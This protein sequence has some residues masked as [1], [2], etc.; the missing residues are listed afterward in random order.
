MNN[1]AISS[2]LTG[3]GSSYNYNGPG[4]LVPDTETG[5]TTK[6]GA[7]ATIDQIRQ[8][9][10][11]LAANGLSFNYSG[12]GLTGI[13]NVWDFAGIAGRGYP[14]LTGVGGQ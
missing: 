10:F 13:S 9:D 1:Y 2:M 12:G 14:L 6:N 4:A 5:P 8:A 3:T 11:W 7:S